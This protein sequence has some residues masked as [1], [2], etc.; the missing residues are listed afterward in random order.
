[1]K[2]R[3][4]VRYELEYQ[5]RSASTWIYAGLLFL[6]TVWI[7]LATGA[8][9]DGGVHANA[10]ELL[11]WNAVRAGM[12]GMLVTAA[13]FGDAAIRD[14]AVEMDPL[15]F[16]SPLGKAEYLGGRFLGALAVNTV[17]LLVI[18]FG[19]LAMTALLA[20]LGPEVL[21]PVRV[22]SYLQPL[23][24][25][26]LPNL[27]LV[28][29][30]LFTIGML[31]RHMVPVYLGAIGMLIGYV[32]AL[33]YA[34]QL[35]SP[36]L[37][38]LVDPFG[39][40]T[41]ERDTRFWTAAERNARL[42]G[43]PAMLAWNRAFWL[44]VAAATL[45][46]LHRSFRFAHADGV[47]RLRRRRRALADI[48]PSARTPHVE[49]PRVAGSFGFGTT[50][51]QTLAVAR[52]SLAEIAASRWFVV[53]L[54][55][56]AGLPMLWGWNVG[57]TVFDTSTW[58]V[59]LLVT[60]EVLSQRSVIFFVVLIFV[61]SGELVWKDR[62]AGVADIADAAPLPDG[63]ALL[64]RFLALVVMILLF[65]TCAM[66]GGMMLQALQGYHD[67]EIG[68]YLRVVFGLKLADYVLLG[69]LA[70]TIHVLVNHKNLGHMAV[71]IAFGFTMAAGQ[72]FG[73]RHNLLLYGRDPGWT[74]S[75]MNGFGPFAGPLVWFKLYWGAWALLLGVLA[76][77]LWVR[78]REP[79]VRRRLRQGRARF[80]GPVVRTAG[81]AAALVAALGGFIF[82][83]TN[84][85]NA[86]RTVDQAG[87]PQAAY[88]ARY[89]QYR[90]LPQPTITDADLRVEIHPDEPA[91]DIRGR[92]QLVN[93]T[94]H[95]IESVHVYVNPDIDTRSIAFDRA[96][97]PVL[98]DEGAGYGIYALG[99]SLLPGDSM[100]LTFDVAFRPRGFPNSGIQ[101]DVV[102]NGAYFNRTWMPFIGYQPMFELRD[103]EARARFGLGP[104][105]PMP[106]AEEAG[107]MQH[108][109]AGGRWG[110]T[111]ADL[112]RVEAIIGTAA[113]QIAITP[114]VLRRSWTENGRRYF[115]YETEAP[116]AFGATMFSANY[117]VLEDRWNGV[118]LRVFHHPAHDDNL[119]RMVRSLKASLEY[120]T[121]QFGPY[122]DTQMRIV[123]IPRYG[124]FGIAHP[125][126]IAFT[127][128]VFFS[129]VREG[130]I[131]QPFYGTAHEVAHTWWGGTVR[132]APVRGAAFLSESLANYSAM[133]VTEKTYGAE[134]GR[135]VYGF[136]MERYLR[137]RATRSREVPLLDVEDQPYIA[138]R[139]GA[140]ALYILRDHI[141]EE[142]VNTAL[143]RYFQ[144][145]RDA[146]PPYPTSRDLY[147]EL[148]AV[149]PPSMHPLLTD[150]FETITLWDVRAERATVQPTGTGHE[151]TLDVVAKKMRAD[152]E[153]RETEVPM[154]DL[155]E[156]GVFASGDGDA[157]GPPLYLQ[158][159]RIRSGRQTIRITVSPERG[160]GGEPARA[161]IDPYRKLIDRQRED[162]IVRVPSAAAAE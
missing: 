138:Y 110:P 24:L 28:G 80:R 23:L 104:R 120:F 48:P 84:V 150:L 14:V 72:V 147:A 100:Q 50:M 16:T 115:H 94:G 67:F 29:A 59:T 35:E 103:D 38:T 146:G 122:R 45:A 118:A 112:V 57:E 21:G 131:D 132:G 111:D 42:I 60:E 69:A 87:A 15:L 4:I 143:R 34:G 142:A 11:A 113:D 8:D 25:L 90:N 73:I 7:A 158:R 54:L 116:A 93:R 91:V 161:G 6:V 159:H 126:T 13:L 89:A 20:Y 31:A 128:D 64:G 41:L 99:Q 37:A 39:L 155:V 65:Q 130:E 125:H 139:K 75:D 108:R 40:V 160:E 49:V 5:L 52:N 46:L 121:E 66:A 68:L 55:A 77:L 9:G 18:P 133:V 1:V 127:E 78:G 152:A 145:Y 76:T 86:Y 117:A 30:I 74:Y 88:E 53:V 109:E 32:V 148:R 134:A 43:L 58:P 151:V 2:L 92:Y 123:E 153:G 81:V 70:M 85:L 101:T 82:Y 156:I 96:S 136:Q 105:P 129:R 27:V 62:E 26:A 61:F 141:G 114:G 95:A 119:D 47:W 124:G 107:T 137:G 98:V 97:T 44:V 3:A 10:P 162:N 63:T 36:L 17:V 51:R 144:K 22:F 33:N 12:F 71:L 102:A 140:I 135:R 106:T 154:D 83:N 56:C 149:T 19:L 79:G 157:P